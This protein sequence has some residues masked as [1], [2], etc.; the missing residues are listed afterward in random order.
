MSFLTILKKQQQHQQQQQQQ[1][2]NKKN[3]N[4]GPSYGKIIT[5][6]STKRS[7]DLEI[8]FFGHCGTRT[9]Q[10]IYRQLIMITNIE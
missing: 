8:Y 3:N 1:H 7:F 5:T 2:D 10:Q 6:R 4:R 9:L